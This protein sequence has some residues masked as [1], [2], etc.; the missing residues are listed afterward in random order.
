MGTEPAKFGTVFTIG[1]GGRDFDDFA[2]LL[3]RFEI[4]YLVDVRSAP[5][6]RYQPEFGKEPLDDLLSKRGIRYVY[7]GDTLGGRPSD[8]SCYVDGRVDYMLCRQKEWFQRG[9]RR[10]RDASQ[11]QLRIA[12]MCSEGKPENC[13]RSKLIGAELDAQG[14]PVIHID[15]KGDAQEQPA[16]LERLTKGQMSFKEN[17]PGIRSRKRYG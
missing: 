3:S 6:S 15:E 16:I 10:L 4:T 7:M 9:I 5:Y 12:L 13:H 8:E 1:H 14:I 11:Q 2:D 17:E